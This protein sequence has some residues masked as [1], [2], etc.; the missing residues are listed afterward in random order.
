MQTTN[1]SVISGSVVA[2]NLSYGLVMSS[3][4]RYVDNWIDNNNGGIAN[5][6]IAGGTHR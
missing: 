3:N 2:T 5:P 6:Q 4:T 1:F